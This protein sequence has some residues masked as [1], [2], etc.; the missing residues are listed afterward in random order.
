GIELLVGGEITGGILRPD[1]GEVVVIFLAAGV[2][3]MTGHN[4]EKT[5]R[6]TGVAAHI[7]KE[8]VD[9]LFCLAAEHGGVGGEEGTLLEVEDQFSIDFQ[10]LQ[11]FQ[12]PV[13]LGVG[14]IEAA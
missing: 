7:T 1:P 5:A 6:A 9:L 2:I 10:A 12:G 3:G 4:E 14:L 13:G 11:V 8:A